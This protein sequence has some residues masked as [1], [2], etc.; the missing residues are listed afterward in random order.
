VN[1]AIANPVPA[2]P[3]SDPVASFK[4]H[5][6]AGD[7]TA[8]LL[9]QLAR[10]AAAAPVSNLLIETGERATVTSSDGPGPQV[11]SGV[12]TDPRFALFQASLAYSPVTMSFDAEYAQA[13]E[14]L[15]RLRDLATTVEIRTFEARPVSDDIPAGAAAQRRIHV[16]LTLFAY[17]RQELAP[18]AGR[19]GVLR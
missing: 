19:S 7:A 17:A 18:S 14:L 15:W 13:G 11:V 2:A 9:E 6:A 12:E 1:A 3:A 8:E 10:V 16:S 4:Q 5:V